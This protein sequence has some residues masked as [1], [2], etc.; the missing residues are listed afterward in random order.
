MERN[1]YTYNDYYGKNK[2]GWNCHIYELRR[3]GKVI[4]R[5]C[6]EIPDDGSEIQAGI[7]HFY[8]KAEKI[9]DDNRVN[10]VK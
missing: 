10:S 6:N 9:L 5:F 1:G 7:D 2:F 4:Y 8:E 3:N